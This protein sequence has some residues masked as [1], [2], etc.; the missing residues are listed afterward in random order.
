MPIRYRHWYI[1][2]LTQHF[3]EQNERKSSNNSGNDNYNK[4]DTKKSIDMINQFEKNL[5]KK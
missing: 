4:Q 3:A 2:R 5:F 1:K